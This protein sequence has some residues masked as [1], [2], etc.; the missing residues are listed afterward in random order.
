M[1]AVLAI[2]RPTAE[3][4]T[5]QAGMSQ[6]PSQVKSSQVNISDSVCIHDIQRDP[7]TNDAR[8]VPVF[9]PFS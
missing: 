9:I 1:S 8:L 5:R 3:T 4:D 6:V 2:P 7:V